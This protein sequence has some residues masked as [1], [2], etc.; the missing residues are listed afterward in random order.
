MFNARPA[1]AQLPHL[2]VQQLGQPLTATELA[3]AVRQLK[4]GKASDHDGVIAEVLK[5]YPVQIG[6]IM[7]KVLN[8]ARTVGHL[9]GKMRYGTLSLVP[10]GGG[11]DPRELG[12]NRPLSICSLLYRVAKPAFRR[13]RPGFR[14]SRL[15]P[16][17]WRRLR[18]FGSSSCPRTCSESRRKS[19]H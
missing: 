11:R 1:S 19:R 17:R 7:A 2:L 5:L 8:A 16:A 3:D 4:S 14:P 6:Y 18:A 12:S 15:S 9:S 10:K 13:F